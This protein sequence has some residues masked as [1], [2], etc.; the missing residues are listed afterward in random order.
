[1]GL[2]QQEVELFKKEIELVKMYR[3]NPILAAQDILRVDLAIPQ[4]AVLWDMWFKNHIIFCAGRGCGKS[5]LDAVFSCLWAMLFP[6][7]KVGLLAPSFRQAKLIFAE[8]DKLWQR[9]PLFQEATDGKPVQ[10]SD[11]CY[12]KFKQA[13]FSAPSVIEAV[14]LGDGCS[15]YLTL[16][17]LSDRF[18]TIGDL[19]GVS[20]GEDHQVFNNDLAIWS[21]GSFRKS[22]EKYYNGQRATKKIKTNKGFVFEATPNHKIK[23]LRDQEIV[24]SSLEDIK[25]GDY[26]PIDRA[27]R[28]HSGSEKV[29]MEQAYALGLL[30][31]DGCWTDK[32]SLRF[33][34]LD[35]ELIPHLQSVFDKSI[36]KCSDGVHYNIQDRYI[37]EDWL[38][39]WGIDFLYTIDKKLP[40]KIL[41]CSRE[42][43]AACLRGLYDTDGHI[44]VS[45]EKGGTAITVGFTNTS[46]HLVDQMQYILLHY[47]IVSV[48][49]QRDRDV[50]WNTCY[51][52]LITG[53][54][55]F[56]FYKE[57]GFGLERKNKELTN[58]IKNK[59]RWV[60]L[61]DGIPN[62]KEDMYR[63]RSSFRVPK[64]KGSKDTIKCRASVIKDST[65]MTRPL[66]DAFLNTCINIEDPFVGRLKKLNDPNIYYDQ[67]VDI[68]DGFCDT[69]DVHVPD[70][71]EYCAGGFFSHNS[72]IRGAR[73][74]C[75]IADE[76]A[77]IPLDIFNTVIRPM[78]AT[79]ADPMENV[80][81]VA[82]IESL[83]KSG[84]ARRE[85]F[86]EG[87]S[88]K[89][90]MTSSAYFTFNHMYET[91]NSF[92][93]L[94]AAGDKTHSVHNVSYRDM[95]KGFLDEDNIINSRAT[96]SS[97]QFRMEYEALWE[98][99]SAGVFKASLIE[100]C[101]KLGDFTVSIKGET[102]KQYILG[103]DPARAADGFALCMI[104]LGQPNRLVAAWEFYQMQFPAMSDLI[105]KICDTFNVA[106][107]HMD[108]G[109]G[110]G[111]LAMKDLLAEES[112]Y[113]NRR[114]LDIEDETTLGLSGRRVLYCF[115]PSPQ[116][117]AEAV[118]AT[119]N[120]ME[121]SQ[122]AFP[123]T[124][125]IM[126]KGTDV[127][128]DLP[129]K[130]E[131]YDTIQ[132]LIRQMMLI[133]VTQSKSGVAHFD[134]PSGGGHAAQ[135]K[136]LYT[137]FYLAAKKAYD[138]NFIT[139]SKS[140]IAEFG[141]VSNLY[142]P[143]LPG[144]PSLDKSMSVLN[145]PINSWAQRK[146]FKPPG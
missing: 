89:I 50:N 8:V 99:D 5:F 146:L 87:P 24:W 60:N 97:I 36:H 12:L 93:K 92:K 78:G 74:Y 26:L 68:S 91:I 28:W 145:T 25:I 126:E 35:K 94:I 40:K 132:N 108:V 15:K 53:K 27:Y 70:G 44:Q 100:E 58:A 136:D 111:G 121:N 112:R 86:E 133:E 56:S 83:I 109:A 39:F 57:I 101:R 54:D 90:I 42:V 85:D 143:K 72:K 107:V 122:M 66:V 10:A 20:S 33:S 131:I 14:P 82:R 124:P 142:Q 103:V 84:K 23:I 2:K 134:V 30:L 69:Y 114:L 38:I 41:S 29:S 62:V 130:D 102:G 17:T 129:L 45:E 13:G 88:N 71:H 80:K 119:L 79:I 125:Q 31:G 6:G 76:F 117:I 37:R 120:L 118:Y 81:R 22:D 115:K 144:G 113:Q 73:Y 98:A 96:L 34:T 16:L 61:D 135:K 105:I 137:A 63:V 55:V 65:V 52:L 106:A 19:V 75:I 51:E 77:Q 47:G 64:G 9:A 7:Q 128:K 110:G 67:V 116:T 4:Q 138:I 141:I 32:Y 127:S 95:P 49:N 43:M 59:I 46:E 48:K 140:E 18:S 21:N 11:K 3:H 139:V 123:Q 104:E 1:M